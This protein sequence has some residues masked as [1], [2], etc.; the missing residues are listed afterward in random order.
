MVTAGERIGAED[1][2]TVPVADHYIRIRHLGDDVQIQQ[3]FL[4]GE[5][6]VQRVGSRQIGDHC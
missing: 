4:T 3:Q 5:L 6:A 1:D 2:K